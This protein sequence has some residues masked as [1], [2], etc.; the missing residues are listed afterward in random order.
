MILIPIK[1]NIH[2]QNIKVMKSLVIGYGSIGKRHIENLSKF[3]N[4]QIS[5]C[6]K[7]KKDKFLRET[8]CKVFSSLDDAL[9]DN[10]EFAIISNETSF[11]VDIAKKLSKSKINFFVEK[12]VSHSM[13]KLDSILNSVKKNN[14]I[15]QVG[16]NYRFNPFLKEIKKLIAKGILGRII[17]VRAEN[18]SYLPDWHPNENYRQSYA[19]RKE[20][21]GGVV[22]TCIHELDYLYWLF[23]KISRVFSITGKYSDLKI[24]TDDLSV[25]TLQ[26]SNN[27]IGE[28]HLDF[29]QTPSSR[30][31]KIIGTKGTL[32]WDFST[33]K[34]MF[35]NSETNKWIV[36]LYLKNYN[37]NDMYVEELKHFINCVKNN[38]ET[39][40]PISMGVEILKI[41]LYV[42][43]SSEIRK[44]VCI[45]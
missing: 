8:N 28:I 42:K 23:G 24:S 11:H 18:G 26:F 3:N 32:F 20:F 33:K 44:M 39:M 40:N 12:P 2:L 21:G 17:S 25:I 7:R 13:N 36:K 9:K 19:G 37:N 5:V 29:Y 10:P 4:I 27:I 38:K 34:L 41:A 45:N 35:F 31:L 16:C 30:Y 15:T 6:T 14:L 1:T 43:K 22:F